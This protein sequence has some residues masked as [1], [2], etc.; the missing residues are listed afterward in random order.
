MKLVSNDKSRQTEMTGR[1]FATQHT[2][3]ERTNESLFLFSTVTID[4]GYP[5][6]WM[7]FSTFV[8]LFCLIVCLIV[9]LLFFLNQTGFY[10]RIQQK[11]GEKPLSI[12][13]REH[14]RCNILNYR[15]SQNAQVLK[16]VATLSC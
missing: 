14:P 7:R 10:K 12:K 2:T 4:D 6:I 5:L 3:N 1:V 9:C 8:F 15:R 11:R 16:Q 13:R